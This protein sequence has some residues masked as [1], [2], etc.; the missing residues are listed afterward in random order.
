MNRRRIAVL[1]D[2]AL[3]D[4]EL[5]DGG[6]IVAE[7][8]CIPH[9]EATFRSVA[10]T[11]TA[12]EQLDRHLRSISVSTQ[13]T[14]RDNPSA[15]EHV[16]AELRLGDPIDITGIFGHHVVVLAARD[17]RLRRFLADLPVHTR[18]NVR[19]LT[20][21][22]FSD[23]V[24]TGERLEDALRFDVITGSVDDFDTW[25]A[26]S[27][28]PLAPDGDAISGLHAR[29]HGANLRAAIAWSPA[30]EAI[31][32]EPLNGIVTV[33]ATNSGAADGRAWAAFVAAVALGIADREAF[34]AV[35]QRAVVAFAGAGGDRDG[36]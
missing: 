25:G 7:L 24:P 15:R 28:P 26:T 19:I 33:P 34:P 5:T 2:T 21:L 6:A 17:T 22:H 35:G 13:L 30:G 31:V 32:A 20:V 10:A 11:A 23:G 14:T 29:M 16:R 27:E 4:G 18:P 12:R 36:T 9:V 1:G 8:A 3:V